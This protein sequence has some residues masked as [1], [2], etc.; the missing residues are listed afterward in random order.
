V[1]GV[2]LFNG[3]WLDTRSSAALGQGVDLLSVGALAAAACAVH[4]ASGFCF[5]SARWGVGDGGWLPLLSQC[6]PPAAYAFAVPAGESETVGGCRCFRS[7]CRQRLLLSQCPLGS[8]RRWGGCRCLRSACR[9]RLLLSQCPL[10]SRRRWVAAAAF[11]VHAAS[12]FCFRSARWGVGDGGGAAAACAVHAA[13]GFCFRSARWGVGNGGWLPLLSQCMPPAASAFAV[14]AGES[15]TVGGAAA[16]CAVH[17]TSGFCFRSARWHCRRCDWA[18][19]AAGRAMVL[20]RARTSVLA[21]PSAVVAGG[22]P[23]TAG[24]AP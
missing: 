2:P 22:A 6:M 19:R 8:R 16:A 21:W 9:Q 18:V 4:A 13:S 3:A 7:A 12:G 20:V 23:H 15:E 5:R 1:R 10:G 11:A 24:A 14:P 17:A